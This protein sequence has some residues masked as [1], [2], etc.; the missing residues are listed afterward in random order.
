MASCEVDSLPS[1]IAR[2]A[3]RDRRACAAQ[4]LFEHADGVLDTSDIERVHDMRV[5]TRRLRAVLEI[6]APCFPTR[7]ASSRVLRDVKAL[8]DALG[9]RRDPDVQIEASAAFARRG[10]GG[11][12]SPGVERLLRR[13]A[14]SARRAGNEVLAAALERGRSAAT[15]AAALLRA[16]ATPPRRRSHE[17]PQGQ[18]PRPRRAAGRQR[19]AHRA[20]SRLDELCAFMPRALDPARGRARCT[21]CASPPSACATSSRSTAPLLRRPT[22]RPPSKRRQGAAGPARRDPRLRRAAPRAC[23]SSLDELAAP[24]PPRSSSARGATPRTSTRALCA[25]APHRRRLARPGRAARSTCA[26]A[27]TCCSRASSSSWQRATSARASARAWSTPSR[28]RPRTR[29]DRRHGS[30]TTADRALAA[31]ISEPIDGP[32]QQPIRDVRPSRPRRPSVRASTRPELY[33]NR[34][35]SWLE[36]NDRVLQ[37]AEDP[38]CRCSSA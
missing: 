1:R 32:A 18:G 36:F 12:S 19:R 28:E 13:A 37:L 34:E 23:A 16:R 27:A 9:E 14:R 20:R 11:P 15:C 29:A 3:A 30:P 5:A 21:T 22:P 2:A 35:L 6:F 7:A 24:T 10:D 38:T 25:Q 26:P 4:E 33:F 17:G 8:A 31:R